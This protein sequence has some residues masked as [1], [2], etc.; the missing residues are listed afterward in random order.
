MNNMRQRTLQSTR[1]S[2]WRRTIR[3]IVA[4]TPGICSTAFAATADQIDSALNKAKANLY[5]QMHNGNWESSGSRDANSRKELVTGGQWGGTTAVAT[6]ALL[7]SGEDPQSPKLAPAIAWLKKAELVGTYAISMRCQVWLRLAHTPETKKLMNADKRLLEGAYYSSGRGSHLYGY[8]TNHSEANLV[9]HSVSQYGV[10]SLWACAEMGIEIPT[11]YWANTEQRWT[12]DQQPDGGWYYTSGP[13][14]GIHAG[15]QASMTAAGVATLF[16]TQ[17]YVHQSEGIRCIG[18]IKNDHIDAGLKWIAS[19]TD[20]WAPMD[21]LFGAFYPGYTLYGIERIGVASGLKYFGT[22]NWYQSGSDWCV[23]NQKP[24]GSWNNIPDTSL[25]MLF[26]ARGRAPLLINKVQYDNAT[27]LHG[28]QPGPWNQRPRDVAN[29]VRWMSTQTEHEQNWQVTNLNVSEEELHDAPF[30]YFS[31]NQPI[32]LTPEQGAKL[33]QYIQRGGM[34]LFNSDCGDGSMTPFLQS[35]QTLAKGLFP[36]YEFRDIPD[37]HPM[38][39]NE[40]YSP[41]RWKRKL[42]LKGLSNGVRELMVLMPTDPAKAWQLQEASGAGREECYQAIDDLLLYG[43]GKQPLTIRGKS[44]LVKLDTTVSTDKSA[45]VLR[46]KYNGNWD[47]E[48]GGWD[49]LAAVMHNQA[50]VD[51]KTQPFELSDK[52]IASCTIAHLT[53]TGSFNP[54]TVQQQRLQNFVQ[55]GGT[56]VIDAAGGSSDFAQSIEALLNKLYPNGLKDPLPAN[57]PVFALGGAAEIHYRAF[58]RPVLGSSHLP[59]LKAVVVNGRNAIY[60]SRYD[61]SAGLVGTPVDGITGYAPDSAT[62]I[63]SG[64]IQSALGGK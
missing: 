12:S 31:G 60:Y 20:A 2:S 22:V 14:G 59:Q 56:L 47:P 62:G 42:S 54:T 16:L 26:L 63:M 27:G 28:G 35:V 3:L 29:F 21:D 7:A 25:C 45:T 52:L 4:L 8:L 33:K 37:S 50:K 64:I 39:T 1:K 9:D 10:L 48:P 15:E 38:F 57:D 13:I 46:L 36:L 6:Y 43:T 17:D 23:L 49:R 11:S 40:Q 34:I 19:H 5:S 51:L 58:A 55:N 53:G 32:S 44:T 18:N 41:A 24:D 30:L 61:L